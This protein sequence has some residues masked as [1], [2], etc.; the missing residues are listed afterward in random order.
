MRGRWIGMIGLLS[1][2]AG[3]AAFP[4]YLAHFTE[5]Y[6]PAEGSDLGRARCQTCHASPTGGARNV[7]GKA[8]EAKL[9]GP[10]QP[11][12]TAALFRQLEA[13]DSDGDG[14]PNGVEIRAGTKP[15]DPESRSAAPDDA[16]KAPSAEATSPD[17]VPKH[18]FHPLIVHFPIGLFLFG[19]FLEFLGIRKRRDSIRQA[20]FWNLAGGALAGVVAVPTGL[21]AAFRLGHSLVPGTLVFGHFVGGSLA[22]LLMVTVALWRRRHAP[23]SP[24]YLTLLALAVALVVAAGHYGG[25]LVYG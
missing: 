5:T 7:Y 24:G 10:G 16:G 19:A 14:V 8:I 6:R 22:T 11:E 12:L 25:S 18:S 13:Q 3:A 17:V 4:P 2:S 23:S 15:G 1:L 20:A 21:F 9:E